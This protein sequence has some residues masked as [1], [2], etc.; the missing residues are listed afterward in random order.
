VA[1]G[2]LLLAGGTDIGL[3]VTK[4]LRELAP[5]VY[6]GEVAELQ[7]IEIGHESPAHRRRRWR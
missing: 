4:H 6:L 7:A 2:S 5:I 1:P 3:W